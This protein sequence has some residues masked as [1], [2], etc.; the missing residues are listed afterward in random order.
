M[1]LR[2]RESL[3]ECQELTHSKMKVNLF[4]EDDRGFTQLGVVVAVLLTISLLLTSAQAYWVE[5]NS[6]DIQSAADLGALAA[7]NVVAEYMV[8]ARLADAIVLSMSLTGLALYGVSAVC[9]CIPGA[10]IAAPKI[11]EGAKHVLDA[12]DSF[13]DSATAALDEM[14]K[15]LP[16][17]CAVE[18]AIVIEENG[19][20]SAIGAVYLG[21]A[22]PVPLVG[23]ETALPDDEEVERAGEEI[24]Q[25]DEEVS[26]LSEEAQEAEDDLNAAKQAGYEAD[27]AD[28][29]SQRERAA[30]LAGLSGAQNPNCSTVDLWSFQMAIDRAKAYYATRMRN[31]APASGNPEEIARSAARS[32]FYSYAYKKVGEGH[33]TTDARGVT[34]AYMPLLPKNTD[35]VRATE[36]YTES[37]YPVSSDGVLHASTACPACG[38][39][40]RYGALCDIDAGYARECPTCQYTIKTVGKTP[41]ASTSID[42]GYEYYYRAVALAA[43]D[44]SEASKR[45]VDAT[46]AAKETTEESVDEFSNALE[47]FKSRRYDPKPPGRYGCVAVV[48]DVAGHES[49]FAI[50]G[51]TGSA[52]IHPR[53]AIAAAA[54][55]PESAT[56]GTNV[57]S[58]LLSGLSDDAIS[59]GGGW[60]A[61]KVLELW[62][63]ML[64]AYGEGTESFLDG[65]ENMLDSVPGLSEIGLARWARETL[66][67]E[68]ELLGLEP[69]KL[70]L[71]RPTLI[72]TSHVLDHADGDIG[73]L[74]G[75]VRDGYGLLNSTELTLSFSLVQGLPDIE[76]TIDLSGLANRG[77]LPTDTIASSLSSG[78]EGK[79]GTRR[80]E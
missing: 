76:L 17:L 10:D 13:A 52:R 34:T 15:A 54:L 19:K 18:A 23:E 77:T 53:I 31:E 28:G 20:A 39:V 5:S 29:G 62:G 6:A 58:S 32:R 41:A 73:S 68:I 12:R 37:V 46:E 8:V 35:E 1:G 21:I 33:V 27:C 60:L 16:F 70:D 74:L 78:L 79:G 3:D 25:N 43:A 24:A 14:Q 51:L 67:D 44:Y 11:A 42:N 7:E 9:A 57:I 75:S 2:A 36:L 40:A 26:E 64:V 63:S 22:I 47:S 65:I 69:V 71:L 45:Y 72:N 59:D 66:E 49:P 50:D 61:E 80:W 56:R 4:V 38:G 48:V 30:H 55:A